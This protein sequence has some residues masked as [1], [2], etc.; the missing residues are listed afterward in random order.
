VVDFDF[1]PEEIV[2]YG[3]KPISLGEGIFLTG[4]PR[5]NSEVGETVAIFWTAWKSR[6]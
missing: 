3:T 5:M 2:R 4:I 1:D 6:L